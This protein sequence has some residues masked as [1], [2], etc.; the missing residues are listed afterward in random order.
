MIYA[1]VDNGLARST[2]GGENWTMMPPGPGLVSVLALDPQDPN[3]VYAGG[4]GGLFAI[5]F[6]PVAMR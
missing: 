1:G 4:P 6:A 2:D 5:R 3:T